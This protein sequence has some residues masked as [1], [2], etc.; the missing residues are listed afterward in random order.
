MERLTMT[1]DSTCYSAE[2]AEILALDGHG[3]R[4]FPLVAGQAP[5]AARDRI[6]ATQLP[7]AVLAGLW[8]Y[9]ADFDGAHR[10]APGDAS[11]EGSYWHGIPHRMEPDAAN[12][13]Y[14]FR[15]AGRHAIHSDLARE[16]R[17]VWPESPVPWDGEQYVRFRD[18]WREPVEEDTAR[19]VQVVEWRLLFDYCARRR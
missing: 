14:C 18:E 6:S 5:G 7:A 1:F 19:A 8:I 4:P 2:I 17:A 9:F 13:M 10:A 11:R 16:A 15:S 12:A 3:S